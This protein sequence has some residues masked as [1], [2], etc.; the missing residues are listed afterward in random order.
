MKGTALAILILGNLFAHQAH[1][2]NFSM[3]PL[4]RADCQKAQMDWDESANAC[5]GEEVLRQPLTRRGCESAGMLWDDRANVCGI[6]SQA[7]RALGAPGAT[8]QPL[9]KIQCELVGLSWND[10]ANV[11]DEKIA[12]TAHAATKELKLTILVKIDKTAQRMTVLVDG[13]QS[14]EWPVSTGLPGYATPS[15]TYTASSMNEIWYSK[16]WDNAPM[17]HAVFFTKRGHAIHGTYETKRLGRPA[18]HGCVRLAPNHARTLF[19][20]VKD[21]GL[22][23]TQVVLNGDTPGGEAKVASPVPRKQPSKHSKVSA[24]ELELKNPR[25]FGG[26]ERRGQRGST[27]GFYQQF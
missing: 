6:E 9:T 3:Q 19:A 14:Y 27:R 20:L 25:R 12:T 7:V 11:C 18:S 4:A 26:R 10:Q 1:A 22:K 21:N 15:G 8:N 17:P 23:N 24:Y 2:E 5:T 13:V 16:E